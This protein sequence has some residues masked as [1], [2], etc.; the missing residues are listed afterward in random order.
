[1]GAENYYIGKGVV[2]IA[3]WPNTAVEPTFVLVGNA[4]KF[5]FQMTE[6]LKDHF[7]QQNN[8]AEQDAEIIIRQGYTIDMTLDEI[9]VEN[10]R[11][12]MKGTR[13]GKLLYANMDSSKYYSIKFVSDNAAGK[14]R[15]YKF[16]KCKL[17]PTGAFSLI[18]DDFT[19][20]GFTGK[21]MSDRTNFASSPF[22]TVTLTTTTTT[23]TTTSI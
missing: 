9:S 11:M 21:G 8:S 7:T 16:H 23:T 20:L 18:S 4:P 12:F 15:T 17:S 3:E 19:T 10:L 22:F 6:E 1:M 14:N 13:S 2:S 5:D